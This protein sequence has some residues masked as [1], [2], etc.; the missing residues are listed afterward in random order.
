MATTRH[1]RNGKTRRHVHR[2]QN[3][4]KGDLHYSIK[5]RGK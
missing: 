3:G 1:T 5:K 2:T 4:V